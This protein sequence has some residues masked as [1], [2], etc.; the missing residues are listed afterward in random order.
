MRIKS[1]VANII[2]EILDNTDATRFS[3]F[4]VDISTITN[5]SAIIDCKVCDFRPPLKSVLED[6]SDLQVGFEFTKL[7]K[8]ILDRPNVILTVATKDLNHSMLRQLL[9]VSDVSFVRI[10]AITKNGTLLTFGF[11]EFHDTEVK[12]TMNHDVIMLINI[13]KLRNLNRRK[14][15]L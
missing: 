3:I 2:R 10:F 9:E 8:E 11:I 6:Y 7:I 15:I 14:W 4:E 13:S 1:E 5:D 12:V